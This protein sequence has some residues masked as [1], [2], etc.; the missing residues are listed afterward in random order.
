LAPDGLS[1]RDAFASRFLISFNSDMNVMTPE[2]IKSALTFNVGAAPSGA[3][4]Q[5]LEQREAM[6]PILLAE[7]DRIADRPQ[8]LLKENRSYILHIL[9]MF[10]LAQF[11]EPRA[12]APLVKICHLPE[13]DLEFLLGDVITESLGSIL[14]S[15]CKDDIAPIQSIVENEELDEFVRSAALSALVTLF[16]EGA[17]ERETL[18]D[19]MRDLSRKLPPEPLMW[20][21]WVLMADDI[22]A[23][24]LLPEIRATY[25]ADLVD[26][27]FI[28]LNEVESDVLEE[29]A[30]AFARLRKDYHYV[31]DA[32]QTLEG[33]ACFRGGEE[34]GFDTSVEDEFDELDEFEEAS[35]ALNVLTRLL[36]PEM[37]YVRETPKTG[38]NDPCPCGSGKKYK[39]CCMPG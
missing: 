39:K 33:W 34:Y 13:D 19:Y 6:T 2:Q 8:D 12:L 35:D 4:R 15:V 21:N 36:Q 16:A 38:R 23:K 1:N 17:L 3:M 9:A 27:G 7:L 5:A 31:T 32:I 24:E 14:A 26:T 30:A 20:T 10:L 25:A 37:P 29:P 11:R 22:Q 28:T 18:V